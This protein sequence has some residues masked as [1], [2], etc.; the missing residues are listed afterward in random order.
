M[1]TAQLGSLKNV[2]LVLGYKRKSTEGTQEQKEI[3][4]CLSIWDLN[5]PHEV[6]NLEKHIEVRTELADKMRKTSVE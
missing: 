3:Q 1:A 5:L 6:Q 4:S 2:M